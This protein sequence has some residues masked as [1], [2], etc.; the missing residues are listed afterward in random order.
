MEWKDP[1]RLLILQFDK[2][3]GVFSRLL[4]CPNLKGYQKLY[5]ERCPYFLG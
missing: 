4:L 5:D 1:K 2:S 3:R